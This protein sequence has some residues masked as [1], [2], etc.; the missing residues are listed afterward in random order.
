MM[1]IILCIVAALLSTGLLVIIAIGAFVH[2]HQ[3]RLHR[4]ELPQL[5]VSSKGCKK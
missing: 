1:A 3:L 2:H 5:V 4:E